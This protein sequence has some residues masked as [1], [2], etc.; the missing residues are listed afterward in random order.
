MPAASMW[1]T[2]TGQRPASARC[3]IGAR[4]SLVTTVAL[5]SSGY[6]L[7]ASVGFDRCGR[8]RASIRHGRTGRRGVGL[9]RG[10]YRLSPGSAG[11]RRQL[12]WFDRKGHETG[13]IGRPESQRRRG[14]CRSHQMADI[15]P[16]NGSGM[17]IPTSGGSSCREGPGDGSRAT[18][19][20]CSPRMVTGWSTRSLRFNSERGVRPVQQSTTN[21]ERAELLL[22]TPQNKTA[23]D[24]SRDGRF[25]LFRSVDPATSHDCGHYPLRETRHRFRWFEPGSRS[26]WTVL[27]RRELDRYQSDESGRSRSTCS[28]FQARNQ[29]THLDE[30]GGADALERRRQGVVLPCAG[31]PLDGRS[32]SAKLPRQCDHARPTGP[33][34]DANVGGSFRCNLDIREAWT[35]SRDGQRFLM[36]TI[37]ERV[38]APP[39]TIILNWRANGEQGNER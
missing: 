34:F 19:H 38:S 13:R 36:N 37:V 28:P 9:R 14:S 3:R 16:G 32:A 4:A 21:P 35:I 12:V 2:S 6:A 33:L 29:G 25:I 20:R 8:G 30:R 17:E 10:S 26:R 7:F 1:V 15:S 23:T 18:G 22:A 5:H 31:R 11:E 24:W 27:S 39:I